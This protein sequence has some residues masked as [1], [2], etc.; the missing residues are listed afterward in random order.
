MALAA[1]AA[2]EE[3]P[4]SADGVTAREIT[5]RILQTYGVAYPIQTILVVLGRLTRKG[6]VTR[7]THP[8]PGLHHRYSFHLARSCENTPEERVWR[9]FQAI[10]DE[11]FDGNPQLA[12]FE[13]QKQ[14]IER[15]IEETPSQPQFL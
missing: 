1:L 9:Q 4:S 6:A 10:A 2:L 8:N 5:N 12:L 7:M 3:E 11:F 14:V 13:L 15:H